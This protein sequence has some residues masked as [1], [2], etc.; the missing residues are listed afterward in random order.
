MNADLTSHPVTEADIGALVNAFRYFNET[1]ANLNTAYQKLEA[2]FVDLNRQLEEKDR[3]LYTR[4]RELD[5][6]TRYLNSLVESLSAGVVA[7]DMD[8]KIT[9]FN[10]AAAEM[11]GIQAESAIGKDYLDILSP[12]GSPQGAY[13][14]LIKGPETR[15]VERRFPKVGLVVNSQTGWVVDSFGERI[16][17]MEFFEDVSTARRL[18][19][20]LEQQKT[21]SA[22]G[23]MA[24]SVAHELRNP[25]AGIGGYAAMLKE[26]L[27]NDAALREMAN[28]I[29]Q[30]VKNLDKIATNLLFLTKRSSINIESFDVISLLEEIRDLMQF[31][32]AAMEKSVKVSLKTPRERINV[33]A[34]PALVR[35][36]FTNLGRNAVQSL[37]S[38]G[39][40]KI[41]LVWRLL[42][43][44]LDITITDTGC[45]IS[46]ENLG[47]LFNP[48]FTTREK[49]TGLGLAL[50]KKAVDLHRGEITV[51][52]E[53][54]KGSRFIVSLPILQDV[55]A[56]ENESNNNT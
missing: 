30:G 44:R 37:G 29:V 2:R 22:L 15:G 25:L 28:S 38:Q 48:F 39:E 23:E 12:D 32:A 45:G 19:E 20:R 26:E 35:M 16:G 50:V 40:I 51:E 17:V 36:V 14:T 5:R 31:E 49:G 56:D 33:S 10:R 52:S 53:F 47:R 21:L 6:V 8:G 34:D 1:A 55:S 9:I 41:A 46:K 3:E 13:L 24:A 18:E 54:G 42:A 43:N 27:K 11:I 7:I 4:L